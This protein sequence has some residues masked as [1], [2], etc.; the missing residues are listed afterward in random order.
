VSD[1]VVNVFRFSNA[2]GYFVPGLNIEYRERDTGQLWQI[3]CAGTRGYLL[4][5]GID[6]PVK[7][8]LDEQA[9]DSHFM[10]QRITCALLIGGAGLFGAEAVGRLLLKGIEG[11]ITWSSHLDRPDPFALPSDEVVTGSVLDWYQ[12]LCQHTILRRAIYDAYLALSHPHEALVFV[13]RGLE[14]LKAGQH[15]TWEDI[16]RDLKVPIKEIKDFT[17]H[18]NHETG[19][20]HASLSGRK[21]RPHFETYG[22]W[23]CGLLD[24]VN[25]ARGRLESTFTPMTAEAVGNAV[26]KAVPLTPYP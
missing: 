13:Y 5:F 12:A 14:W 26:A 23:V 2:R 18:A 20:R 22:T 3:N 19:V 4:R 6:S 15:L 10:V 21:V 16:A 25:A 11:D 24:A 7:D 8:D 17:K 9:S 1:V